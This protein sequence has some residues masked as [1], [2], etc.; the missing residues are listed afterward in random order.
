MTK[1][2]LLKDLQK[3][4]ERLTADLTATR[5]KN[6]VYLSQ[7]SYDEQEKERVD[8]KARADELRSALDLAKSELASLAA[9]FEDQKKAH[10]ALPREHATHAEMVCIAEREV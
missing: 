10:T 1:N 3:E 8:L 9:L 2:A 4:I 7:Q 6:G 5:E